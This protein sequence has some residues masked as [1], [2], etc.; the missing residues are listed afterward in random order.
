MPQLFPA[1]S[2]SPLLARSVR[3]ALLLASTGLAL[4]AAQAA[5]APGGGAEAPD[6]ADAQQPAAA[7][8]TAAPAPAPATAAPA[9]AA[10]PTRAA[11]RSVQRKLRLRADGVYGARTRAAVRRFQRRRGL[12]ADGRLSPETLSALGVVARAASVSPAP[13]PSPD[14]SRLLAAIA[15]CESGSNPTKVSADGMHR[16]KYQF[17]VSTWESVGGTGDP[18]AA[19]EAEQDQR[20]AALL[21]SEGTKPWPVCGPQAERKH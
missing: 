5:A 2:S 17:L 16:G 15:Q 6:P 18:A 7:P 20:A 14:A 10:K 11:I 3:R 9:P 13:A 19:P 21:A 1:R 8:A 12:P 4:S